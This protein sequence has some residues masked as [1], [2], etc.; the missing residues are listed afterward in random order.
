[1]KSGPVE[2]QGLDATWV[3]DTRTPASSSL[4][5]EVAGESATKVRSAAHP[6]R[7]AAWK[8]PRESPRRESLRPHHRPLGF[9]EGGSRTVGRGPGT[10]RPG[11]GKAQARQRIA[12]V[13]WV[14]KPVRDCSHGAGHK[15]GWPAPRDPRGPWQK[16][17][18]QLCVHL[19]SPPSTHSSLQTGL[20]SPLPRCEA[21]FSQH[22]DP[23]SLKPPPSCTCSAEWMDTERA[24][25]PGW[26]HGRRHADIWVIRH[27]LP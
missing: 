22:R 12:K 3:W 8:C 19:S 25:G 16:P 5:S 23:S 18:S 17:Q 6:R 2:G 10:T 21:L 7:G 9:R 14:M 4:S 24:A 27:S 1:M 15:P 20:C 13:I 11:P 26:A